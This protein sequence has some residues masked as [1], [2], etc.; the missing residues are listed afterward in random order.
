M[1]RLLT[2]E[3]AVQEFSLPSAR[4]IRTLRNQGLPTAELL[5]RLV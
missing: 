1:K 3:Q 2:I 5:H 4:T